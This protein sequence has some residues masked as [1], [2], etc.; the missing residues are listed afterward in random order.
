MHI[1]ACL[2]IYED[3]E[4]LR[5]VLGRCIGMGDIVVSEWR[6]SVPVLQNYTL[7]LLC[8]L[9]TLQWHALSYLTNVLI[10]LSLRENHPA[11]TE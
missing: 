2:T 9:H 10:V 4:H 6:G 8:M 3:F 5:T 11:G 1:K 7:K